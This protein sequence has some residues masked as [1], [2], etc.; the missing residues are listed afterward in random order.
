MLACTWSRASLAFPKPSCH[1]ADVEQ[2]H[3]DEAAKDFEKAIEVNE[4]D[5]DIYYH[6]AQ[7]N[8]VL[9]E[10]KEASKDYQKSID[11][12][13]DFL[14]SHIQL[15]VTQYKM[16]SVA[17]SMSTFRRCR[18]NFPRVPDVFNYYGELLLDQQKYQEAL[19]QFEQ[20]IDLE[21]STKPMAMNVLP[22][23]NKSLTIFQWQQ[24]FEDAR[25]LCEK[26][27][28]SKHDLCW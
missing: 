17:S 2:G 21:K 3:R 13:K 26:A 4:D 27:L 28:K 5:P 9:G 23:V 7:L 25:E 19:E 22:L 12:D 18:K 11:L 15:G 8:F 10:F 1:S 14:F 6:R 20:A 16:G 24:N